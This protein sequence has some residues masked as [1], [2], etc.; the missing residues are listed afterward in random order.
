MARRIFAAMIMAT[1]AGIAVPAGAEAPATFGPVAE[2][3]FHWKAGTT[4]E[5]A[6]ASCQSNSDWLIVRGP[7]LASTKSVDV[8][9]RTHVWDK[10]SFP[11]SACVAPDCYQL[12]VKVTDKDA[13]G[14]RTVTLTSKDGK[15]VTTTF[16]VVE[17]AGRC[18]YPQGQGK[19]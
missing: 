17:N 11:S 3:T 14:T 8:T 15:K 13:P 2:R 6:G 16:D 7:G 1:T 5:R 18:D 4:I 19:K 10:Q 12:F 9:P